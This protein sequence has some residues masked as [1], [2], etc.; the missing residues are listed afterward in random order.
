MYIYIYT[1]A[2]LKTCKQ[3]PCTQ[4]GASSPGKGMHNHGANPPCAMCLGG[5]T[6]QRVALPQS[7]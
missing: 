6:P 3:P 4:H 5:W 7:I 2:A 1:P